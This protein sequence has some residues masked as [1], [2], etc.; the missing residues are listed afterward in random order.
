MLF[1]AITPNVSFAKVLPL[2]KEWRATNYSLCILFENEMV[3]DAY[4]PHPE[5][6]KI[7][8]K[9]IPLLKNGLNFVI[10]VDWYLTENNQV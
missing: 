6:Q 2:G 8:E 4:I 7:V 3:R 10:A 1:K 9:L 5:P